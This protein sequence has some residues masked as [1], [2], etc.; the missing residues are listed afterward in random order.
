MATYNGEKFIKKQVE[1]ILSQINEDDEL[2]ISD[3]GSTDAT[4]KILKEFNDLRIKIY[5]NQGIRGPV[6]NFENALIHATGEYIFLSDQDDIWLPDRVQAALKIHKAGYDI[7]TCN[8]FLIDENDNKLSSIPYFNEKH[9]L[10][11]SFFHNLYE[12]SVYGCCMS[13]NRQLLLYALPFPK[14]IIMHDVWIGMLAKVKFKFGYCDSC[15]ILYR[16]HANTAS[17]GKI[18]GGKHQK[19]SNAYRIKTR[20]YLFF[21]V[22]IRVIS[23][24]T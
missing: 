23:K 24:K 12:N 17:F 3:D 2:I 22:I 18:K 11:R 14:H 19:I 5:L 6:S 9:P 15:L 7:V 13:F 10:K 4:I 21:H 20:L 1:T 8:C 16:R